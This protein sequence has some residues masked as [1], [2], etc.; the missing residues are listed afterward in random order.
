MLIPF[1][2]E[3]LEPLARLRWL[4][5]WEQRIVGLGFY[6]QIKTLFHE[7]KVFQAHRVLE[8]GCGEGSLAAWFRN[9]QYTGVDRDF[10]SL[11]FASQISR[12]SF[13]CEDAEHLSF[14][15]ETFDVVISVAILHHLSER[16][17]KRHLEEAFRVLRPQGKL[18][19]FDSLKPDPKDFLRYWFSSLERGDYLRSLAELQQNLAQSPLSPF[20]LKRSKTLFLQT[21]ST[22]IPKPPKP[23]ILSSGWD[24]KIL[25]S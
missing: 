8:I 15:D 2:K 14:R 12:G 1:L 13:I 19:I 21:Y 17:L 7:E 16:Q 20:A 22:V 18:I 6:R 10:G 5:Y 3:F 25:F 24:R 23:S 4:H 9:G 11:Q